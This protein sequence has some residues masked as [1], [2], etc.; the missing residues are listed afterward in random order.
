MYFRVSCCNYRTTPAPN[1]SKRFLFNLAPENSK[2]S[3]FGQTFNFSEKSEKI[4]ENQIHQQEFTV[5]I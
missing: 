5:Q 4:T 3:N 2:N 1:F